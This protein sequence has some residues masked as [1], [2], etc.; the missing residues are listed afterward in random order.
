MK[1]ILVFF[2]L[3]TVVLHSCRKR[4]EAPT[5]ASIITQGKW[6]VNLMKSN[7]IN[8]TSSYAGWQFTFQTDKTVIVTNSTS[9]FNGTWDEDY[10][11]GKFVLTINSQRIEF[12][13]ISQ[14]WDIGLKTF[15]KIIFYDDKLN[16]SQ[17]LQF[18]KF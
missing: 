18:T 13:R 6:Y 16:P 8:N 3:L 9:S 15:G 14:E 4:T 17:E 7:G 12:I 2:L 10:N 1:K 11:L 5:L